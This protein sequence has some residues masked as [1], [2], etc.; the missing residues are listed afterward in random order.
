[1]SN[2]FNYSNGIKTFGNF[3]TSQYASDYIEN[4][5]EKRVTHNRNDC[6]AFKN[7]STQGEYLKLKNIKI[8]RKN[9]YSSFNKANLNM[10]LVNRLNLNNVCVI[11]KY[12]GT[13]P[14][15]INLNNIPNLTYIIDPS[16]SLFGDSICGLDNYTNYLECTQSNIF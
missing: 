16:G 9:K 6:I 5:S 8:T 12:T 1:M 4:V 11:K 14:A 3:G 13:C 2:K 15:N 7:I 10:N